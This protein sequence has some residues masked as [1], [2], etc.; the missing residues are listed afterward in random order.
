MKK[1]KLLNVLS[2]I[3][4]NKQNK[5]KFF[6]LLFAILFF[7][8]VAVFVVQLLITQYDY[9]K[10]I[11]TSNKKIPYNTGWYNKYEKNVTLDNFG[12]KEG[13]S[14]RKY[15]TYYHKIDYDVTEGS[16]LCFRT[17]STDVKLYI[18]G[19]LIIDTPYKHSPLAVD[20]SGSVWHFYKFNTSDIGKTLTI[21]IRPFYKDNSCYITNMYVCDSGQYVYKIISE[22]A[23]FFIFSLLL[24]IVGVV[25]M[26]SN[27]LIASTQHISSSSLMYIGCFSI[28]LGLY[29]ATSTH[30]LELIFNNS[31]AIQTFA[32]MSLYLIVI[33]SML[34]VDNILDL[35]PKKLVYACQIINICSFTTALILQLTG[36]ADFHETL[37]LAHLNTA[38]SIT[39]IVILCLI[40]HNSTVTKEA[41]ETTV[42]TDTKTND[43][44]QHKTVRNI[45]FISTFICIVV[46]IVMFI[47]GTPT[48]G[49][50][51]SCNIILIIIYLA[52]ISIDNL[53]SLSNTAEHAKFVKQ[54]AY[55]DGLTN[56]G[57]R[58]AYI[59]KIQYIKE[60]IES[61]KTVGIVIFDVNNL[62][63]INDTLGHLT[64]DQLII[65]TANLI[66]Q[67]FTEHCTLFRIGGDEFAVIIEAPNSEAIYKVS[68]M[69][70]NVNVHNH[71]MFYN[72]KY[73]ISVAHGSA[74]Y[75]NNKKISLDEIIKMADKNMYENKQ[76]MKNITN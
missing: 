16:S 49:L 59:E 12:P 37:T 51:S 25:F 38:I 48:P 42:K 3:F 74:F 72:K 10:S 65:D 60:H 33:P 41:K 1:N 26:A 8:V 75:R 70:F 64:G 47:K 66:N 11:L 20:S 53:F 14:T 45:I 36:I 43:K 67:S 4:C 18:D 27:I 71:N 5:N 58:T 34:F 17:L 57:N 46:D 22:N 7:F 63:C 55:K 40:K 76:N 32:C 24:I 50:Y 62:K 31:Q 54:L 29:T 69:Q 30:I 56:V 35:K 13:F 2:N 44:R 52:C 19:K 21:K 6:S 61:Y 73:K 23:I 9:S 68:V 15:S 28:A 39:S